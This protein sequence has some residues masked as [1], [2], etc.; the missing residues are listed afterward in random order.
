MMGCGFGS[1]GEDIVGRR[2]EALPGRLQH[3]D[4]LCG[5]RRQCREQHNAADAAI[6]GAVIGRV[7]G[8]QGRL[9]GVDNRVA[10]HAT[11]N[12]GRRRRCVRQAVTRNQTRQRHRIGRGQRNN[13]LPRWPLN[14]TL[15]QGCKTS[16]GTVPV[17]TGAL[18]HAP[19]R[20]CS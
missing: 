9:V 12:R 7:G 6:V 18:Y 20:D 11:R 5:R 14:A 10:D 4:R 8:G 19:R 15:A 1:R 13:A 2:R 16:S 3:A 17:T